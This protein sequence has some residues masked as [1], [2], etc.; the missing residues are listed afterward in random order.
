MTAIIIILC[1]TPL[2]HL[3]FG[4]WVSWRTWN[5]SRRNVTAPAVNPASVA[6]LVAARN[7]E[8]N[9]DACLEALMGQS[10]PI[11]VVVINDDSTDDTVARARAWESRFSGRLSVV[12]G[13]PGKAMAL[14]AGLAQVDDHISVILTCDADCAPPP[15][16][17]A[18]LSAELVATEAAAVGGCTAVRPLGPAG[19]IESLDWGILLATAAALSDSGH[20]LTAMGNNMALDREAL[21]EVGGFAIGASSVTEDY[22]LFR[23]LGRARHTAVVMREGLLN[24]TEPL[25]SLCGLFRQRRRWAIGAADGRWINSAILVGSASAY[26]LPWLLLVLAPPLALGLFLSRWA[27][28]AV[29]ARGVMRRLGIRL[30]LAWT[31]VHDLVISIYGVL[32]P[33]SIPFSRRTQWKGRAVAEG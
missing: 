18:S 26:G 24:W 25:Q 8:A 30:P 15:A 19:R 11:S 9:I 13:G 31:P 10:A 23:E 12:D 14:Q 5:P 4:V 28:Q 6:C 1:V 29:I 22:V 2:A 16:W 20:T 33:L 7:E 3:A 21:E 17:A 32:V 27:V